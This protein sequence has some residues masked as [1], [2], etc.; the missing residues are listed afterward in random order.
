M[1]YTSVHNTRQTS[2]LNDAVLRANT[3][4]LLARLLRATPDADLLE[5]LSH[6]ETAAEHGRG[7]GLSW[8][9]LKL[10]ASHA[11][12]AALDDEYHALFIGLG[13]G[14]VIPYGSW[15]QTGYLMDTPLAR[16][17]Y[18]LAQLGI[19]RRDEVSEPE[20]HAAALCEAMAILIDKG[21]SLH[22]QQQ[23]FRTHLHGWLARC[24]ADIEQAP[25]AHFYKAVGK[26]G[27]HFIELEVRYLDVLDA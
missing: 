2:E 20:D 10:S 21:T 25:S 22:V 18:D 16:L 14:E 13:H 8:H 15:Y 11:R 12:P 19:E 3:Y 9:L 23:F 17:R 4:T 1:T 27:Q 24:F 26:L 5:L 6:I 7:L